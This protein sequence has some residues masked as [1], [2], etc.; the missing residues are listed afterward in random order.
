MRVIDQH[1]D[2]LCEGAGMMG[3]L[4]DCQEFIDLYK[5]TDA[6][7]ADEDS[8][9]LCDKHLDQEKYESTRE[10]WKDFG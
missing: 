9:I 8:T 3:T 4:G 10:A 6:E 2:I 1:G 7:L 5:Y